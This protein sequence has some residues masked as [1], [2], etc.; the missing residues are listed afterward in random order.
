MEWLVG[1]IIGVTVVLV[2]GIQKRRAHRGSE[3]SPSVVAENVANED[4][5]PRP[6]ELRVA[7]LEAYD[8]GSAVA[9]EAGKEAGFCHQ[10]GVLE[11][12]SAILGGGVQDDDRFTMMLQMET[13]PFNQLPPEVGRIAVAEYLVWKLFP[14]SA[15]VEVLRGP[16]ANFRAKVFADAEAEEDQDGIIYEMLYSDRNDWQRL[17]LSLQEADEAE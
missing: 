5:E 1:I 9:K 8:R 2:G 6:D 11:A 16:L 14:Q 3:Q 4:R 17:A 13:V 15:D 12:V 7:A 10:V